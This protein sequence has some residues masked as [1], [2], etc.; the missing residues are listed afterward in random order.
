MDEE[1]LKKLEKAHDGIKAVQEKVDAQGSKLDAIDQEYIKKAGE[2]AA[3]ALEAVQKANAAEKLKE[4]QDQMDEMQKSVI[5]SLRGNDV[6]ET[7]YKHELAAYMKKGIAP[8]HD[9]V[10]ENIMNSLQKHTHGASDNELEM[11]A[12]DLLAGSNPDGGFFLTT[13]RSNKI[14]ERIFETSPLRG[15]ANIE[16]TTGDMFEVLLDDNESDS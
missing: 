15:V 11:L 14:S 2:D 5:S 16:T 7:E 1:L 9:L 8:E 13:D 10:K 4:M 12:K 3:N 6:D